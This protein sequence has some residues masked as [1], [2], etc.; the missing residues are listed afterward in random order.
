[1]GELHMKVGFIALGT[2]KTT[3]MCN[4]PKI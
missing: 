4:S 3:F 2:M 1:L